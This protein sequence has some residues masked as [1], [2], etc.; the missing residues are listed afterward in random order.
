MSDPGGGGG[1]RVSMIA[2]VLAAALVVASGALLER[3]LGPRPMVPGDVPDEVTGA[4]FCPHGG[5]GRWR[6]WVVVA[7]PSDEGVGLRVATHGPR[8]PSVQRATVDPG[9]QLFLEV[10][11]EEMA[12]GTSVEF[13]GGPVAAGMVSARDRERGMAAEPCTDAAAGTW[14]LPEG[15]TERGF[16]QRL[17]LVN[18][19][20]ERAV[21]GITLVAEE[22]TIRPGELSGVVIPP[23]RAAAVDLGGFAL[24]KRTLAAA[25]EV[26]LG[27]V[28]VAGVGLTPRGVRTVVG[29]QGPSRMWVLPGAAD[30]G[31]T[32]ITLLAPRAPVPFR[33]RAQDEEGQIEVVGEADLAPRSAETVELEAQGRT[34]VV[35]AEGEEPFVAAR[36]LVRDQDHAGTAG[37]VEGGTRWVAVPATGPGGGSSVLVVEN[38]GDE[39]ADVRISLLTAEGRAEVPSIGRFALPAGRARSISLED[40]VGEEPVS[41]LVETTQGVVV[42]AQAGHTDGGY[43]VSTGI[44]MDPLG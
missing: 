6:T 42:V 39:V 8:A 40:L 24:G 26:R 38:P 1:F 37:A 22:E 18:P 20:P 5:G 14:Y 10:P 33:V 35:V 36:R 15:T 9:S 23:R 27:K 28:A 11:A 13:F 25:V 30:R 16:G 21:V 29:V 44:R 31:T 7:N 43:A 34:L 4:W 41:A 3:R 17:V 19:F 32:E 2:A 12:S